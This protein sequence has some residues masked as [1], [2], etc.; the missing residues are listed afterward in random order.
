MDALHRQQDRRSLSS[1]GRWQ[2]AAARK[3]FAPKQEIAP[4]PCR[5]RN[6]KNRVSSAAL[7][8]NVF[9]SI[10]AAGRIGGASLSK[11]ALFV[12]GQLGSIA[13]VLGAS[14]AL[15]LA[16]GSAP[17]SRLAIARQRIKH[18]IV[19]MQENRSFDH[20]FG[21]FPGADGIPRNASGEPTVCIPDPSTG[22][23][24]R[25][26][27]DVND[28]NAGGPHGQPSALADINGGEM[29]GFLAQQQS[30]NT[31]ATGCNNPDDPGCSG[32]KAGVDRKDAVGYHTDAEIPNYW[33]YA[34]N[35]VL[36]DRMF[37]SVASWS[38]P[39]H[40]YL[41]SEWSAQCTPHEPL[42]C[43]TD[44]DLTSEL[45]NGQADYPWTDLTYL[46]HQ[47]GVSW[48]YYLTEGLEPDCDPALADCTP[49]SLAVEVSSIWNPLPGFEDVAEDRELG[50]I[51]KIDR[52][53]VDAKRGTLPA[54]SWIVPDDTV[55]EHPPN[56]VSAGHAY[57]TGLI[58][59]VMQSAQWQD[60]AIFL[61]WDD[62]GGFYD[63]VPPPN[64]DAN[65]YG[66][67]VPALVISPYAKRGFIDHQTLSFDAYTKFIEDLFLD[68]ARLDP[69]SDGRPDS[70]PDVRENFSI[71]GDLLDDFDFNQLP[72]RP[73]LVLKQQQ[74]PVA[75]A[76]KTRASSR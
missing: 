55:S 10:A 64:V 14:A 42:S 58:N 37:E 34:K 11:R 54:V 29:N 28:I 27:H 71:L 65:G 6:C 60:T 49:G 30:G 17:A 26:F 31:G 73:P 35:F 36:Q 48:K 8:L 19:I 33:A 43:V 21:T 13:V 23:C 32:V 46:L 57:V 76:E 15:Y 70:R 67:R 9:Q 38:L 53:F 47:A 24:V 18:V 69:K 2:S 12:A 68:G 61:A 39:S 52:F 50:N 16:C 45:N 41:V 63:H 59:A 56:A 51:Q 3:I 4:Q 44:L 62:W 5:A 25:P 72:P 66:L 20:Y 1:W 74:R 22:G 75:S 40:L 7:W